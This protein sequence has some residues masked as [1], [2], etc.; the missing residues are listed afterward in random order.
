MSGYLVAIVFSRSASCFYKAA[1]EH[2]MKAEKI[3]EFTTHRLSIYLRCLAALDEEGVETIS[4]KS[5]AER[6]NLNSAQI[7]KDLAYFGQFGVRGVGYPVRDLRRRISN[8]LGLDS[9]HKVCV[10]GGGNLGMAL[11]EYGGFLQHGFSVVAVFEN[12][13]AKIGTTWRNGVPVVSIG[14]LKETVRARGI[15]MAMIAVPAAAAREV[16]ERVFDAGIR[17]ILNFAPVRVVPR[18]GTKIQSIDLSISLEGLSFFLAGRAT[19]TR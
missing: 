16:C 17:A 10:I 14:D 13:P 12:S 1:G 2:P 15:E 3:S 18:P 7:R 6:F 5:L 11:A 9:L 19:G 8:I 4:S